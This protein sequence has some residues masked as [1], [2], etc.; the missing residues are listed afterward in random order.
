MAKPNK[1]PEASFRE[2]KRIYKAKIKEQAKEIRKLLKKVETLEK[3]LEG[4]PKVK[5]K[6]KAKKETIEVVDKATELK[7]K[8]REQYC[9]G[10]GKDEKK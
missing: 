8:L 3:Q 1:T 10:R 5:H 6:I 2:E 7:R 9:K 4:K